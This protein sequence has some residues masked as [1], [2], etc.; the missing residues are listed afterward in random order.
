MTDQSNRQFLLAKRTSGDVRRDD[1]T[2]QQAPVP[3]LADGQNLVRNKYLSLD[4]PIRASMN[5]A[6]SYIPPVK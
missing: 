3:S 5:E 6:K 4:P 1:L 2:Y